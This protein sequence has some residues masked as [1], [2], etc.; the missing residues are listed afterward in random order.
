MKNLVESCFQ[1]AIHWRLLQGWPAYTAAVALVLVV[2]VILAHVAFY[3]LDPH[4]LRKFPG[5]RLAAFS[6]LWLMQKARSG[7]RYLHINEAHKK[8]GKY[9]RISPR[10][11]SIADHDAYQ[12]L[13]GHGAGHMKTVFYDAFVGLKTTKHRGLFNCT[14]RASTLVDSMLDFEPYIQSYLRLA[15]ERWDKHCENARKTEKDGW[16]TVDCLLWFN[17][18]A[19]DTI[20]DLCFGEP[21]GMTDKEADLAVIKK[22]DGSVV[23]MPAIQILNERGDYSSSLGVIRPWLRPY[24]KTLDPWFRKGNNS[25][26]LLAGM[27][28]AA[29]TKR[30]N[31][32][33]SDRKDIL[34]RLTEARDENGQPLSFDEL[35]A[36]AISMLI[37][38]SD[39][40][41]NT[42][43]AIA[44]YLAKNVDKQKALQAELDEALGNRETGS[45]LEFNDV[46]AL[47]YLQA[48][49]Y[50]ALRMHN[51][52]G[53]GLPRLLMQDIDF[54]GH[55]LPQGTECSVPTYTLNHLEAIWGD[56]EVYRPERWLG[57]EGRILEKDFHPF[58]LGPRA[59]V[60][61]NLALMQLY[62]FIGTFFYRYNFVLADPKQTVLKS[63]E[64]LLHKP[65]E[66]WVKV[67]RRSV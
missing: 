16:W 66:V 33:N 63:T 11:L 49:I 35:V 60:G 62:T 51:T 4:N 38:G 6:D 46:K 12:V 24:F 41:S 26:A 18:L 9:V 14:D 56:P 45:T 27:A 10:Q 13:Y 40:T 59:C 21:F 15:V 55:H 20:S 67:R 42:S 25:V 43:S 7:K 61:R 8:Y 53:L 28:R 30:L 5:P 29:V 3:L 44:F 54:K 17:Y 23:Y 19:F 47:P 64:G 58:S 52:L 39:T 37:G 1:R 2:G 57:E 50:E 65:D 34:N 48:A 31:D 36:E 22:E 32:A